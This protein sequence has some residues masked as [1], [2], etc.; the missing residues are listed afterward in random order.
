VHLLVA[1]RLHGWLEPAVVHGGRGDDAVQL[2]DRGVHVVEVQRVDA[3]E[4]AERA[5]ERPR[6]QLGL[7][8]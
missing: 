8:L 6:C 2:D 5:L 3:V 7:A 1:V 4:R